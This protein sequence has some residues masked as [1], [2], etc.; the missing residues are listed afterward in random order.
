MISRVQ[1]TASKSIFHWSEIPR[2]T[3]ILQLEINYI[4]VNFIWVSPYGNVKSTVEHS[5]T[6]IGIFSYFIANHLT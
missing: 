1:P 2:S 3:M 5:L 4:L 6:I